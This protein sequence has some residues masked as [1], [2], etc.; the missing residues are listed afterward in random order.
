MRI[1]ADE[2]VERLV[3]ERLRQD[4][5]IVDAIAA[6]APGT[7]DPPILARA[8]AENVVLLTADRDFGDY[9]YRDG[10]AAPAAGLVLYRLGNHL[11]TARKA[12]IIATTFTQ[13]ATYFA[14]Q[15]TVIDEP[16]V[17]QRPLP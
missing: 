16:K 17:R 6:Q 11:S 4:G 12:D 8:V 5:H 15:F 2:N 1:L 7:L 10:L 14:G 9:I 13:P 3:I